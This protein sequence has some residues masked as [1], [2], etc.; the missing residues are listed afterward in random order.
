MQPVPRDPAPP[1]DASA[2]TVLCTVSADG[3]AVLDDQGRFVSLNPAASDI[4]G[5]CVAQ[6]VGQKSPFDLSAGDDR[7]S[8][9][10][11]RGSWLAPDGRQRDLEFRLAPLGDGGFAVWFSDVTD[12]LRQR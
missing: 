5:H 3:L 4:L 9:E 1:I 2:S 7:S 12:A 6:L 8:H 10:R 11:L